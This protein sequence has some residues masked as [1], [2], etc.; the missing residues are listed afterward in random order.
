MTWGDLK[1]ALRERDEA[2]AEKEDAIRIAIAQTN[3]T[4]A[5]RAEAQALQE[6]LADVRGR[7]AYLQRATGYTVVSDTQETRVVKLGG[8]R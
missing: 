2:R 5:A 8:S 1:R 6:E 4:R 7:L 3:A